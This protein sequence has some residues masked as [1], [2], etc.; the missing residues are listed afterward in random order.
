MLGILLN[1]VLI[2]G[3]HRSIDK[4]LPV[5]FSHRVFQEYF[6]A[7]SLV[8]HRLAADN[9]PP[10]VRSFCAELLGSA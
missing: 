1:S 6:L 2:S 7:R 10:T 9:Y 3:Q 5:M 4:G 8:T